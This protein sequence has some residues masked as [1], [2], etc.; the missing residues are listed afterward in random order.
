MRLLAR[1]AWGGYFGLPF[2]A[3]APTIPMTGADLLSRHVSAVRRQHQGL[4]GRD[5]SGFVGHASI[6]ARGGTGEREAE[7]PT[8]I[9]RAHG[10]PVFRD[11]MVRDHDSADDENEPK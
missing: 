1:A 9:R 10:S 2:A 8:I 3:V 11:E 7:D 5:G 4:T 6:V